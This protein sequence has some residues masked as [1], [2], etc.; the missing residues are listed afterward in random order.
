MNMQ[1]VADGIKLAVV[2]GI[3][4]FA[5]PLWAGAAEA[6]N[7]ISPIGSDA[8]AAKSQA[9]DYGI[10][11]GKTVEEGAAPFSR[12]ERDQI[13]KERIAQEEKKQDMAEYIGD[14]A[15]TAKVKSKFLSREGLN[16]LDI[17]VITV[18]GEVTLMGDVDSSEQIGLAETVAKEVE[19]VQKVTNRLVVQP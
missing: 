6:R 1:A 3:L 10:Q 16:S 7:S 15:V 2:T 8:A 18:D 11:Q 19:G 12:E 17:K 14:A 13:L 9:A 5:I 4:M